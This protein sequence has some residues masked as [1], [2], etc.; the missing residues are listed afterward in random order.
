MTPTEEF[1]QLTDEQLE[2]LLH[3]VCLEELRRSQARRQPPQEGQQP[4]ADH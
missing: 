4:C 3:R 1:R 2:A